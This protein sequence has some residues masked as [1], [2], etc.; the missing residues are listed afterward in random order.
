[1]SH[2][3]NKIKTL[4]LS[5]QMNSLA[6]YLLL[7][8]PS[9]INQ[10]KETKVLYS[11]PSVHDD[12]ESC[13]EDLQMNMFLKPI[14]CCILIGK[15]IVYS[16]KQG[17]KINILLKEL[18]NLVITIIQ[19]KEEFDHRDSKL[20]GMTKSVHMLNYGS[21]TLDEILGVDKSVREKKGIG[22]D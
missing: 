22:F 2:P 21:D 19:L 3:L 7:K 1:M 12:E 14:D 6:H 9:T 17:V 15:K 11:K 13:D 4:V 5:K 20:E 18:A 16:Q 8:F 10:R